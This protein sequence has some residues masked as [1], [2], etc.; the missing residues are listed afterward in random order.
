MNRV[1]DATTVE[2]QTLADSW[3]NRLG[4]RV[5]LNLLVY[6]G[7]EEPAP[8]YFGAYVGGIGG[9]FSWVGHGTEPEIAMAEAER[10]WRLDGAPTD[11]E[12]A[13]RAKLK[14]RAAELGLTI[15]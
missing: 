5:A 4:I 2:L 8:P 13:E 12:D 7:D 10:K 14:A 9:E 3:S 6:A 11:P 15:F 1:T